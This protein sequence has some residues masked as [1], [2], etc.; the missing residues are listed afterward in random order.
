MQVR[1]VAVESVRGVSP[2]CEGLSAL[3]VQRYVQVPLCLQSP[4]TLTGHAGMSC[5]LLERV[6]TQ[7]I[8]HRT[9]SSVS[10]LQLLQ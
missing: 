5:V 8:A 10:L 6:S 9:S 7:I 2:P 1:I 3:V 4:L